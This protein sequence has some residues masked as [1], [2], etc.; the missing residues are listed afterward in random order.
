MSATKAYSALNARNELEQHV[1]EDLRKALA[2]RGATVTHYGTA[3]SHAPA[4]APCDISV[5]YGVGSTR[6]H[7]MVEVAQRPDASEFESIV[8]H[9]DAW[10]DARGSR[11]NLLYSGRS[12]SARM[13][14]LVRNENERRASLKR[15]GRIVFMKLDDLR[16]YLARWAALPAA[17]V[18]ATAI[19][20]VFK[21]T[22][23]FRD[24]SATAEVFRAALF[25][26]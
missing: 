14:R 3:A 26:T 2:P 22:D 8:S 9:L 25:P 15:A 13:A 5:E 10:V 24:D 11:V 19:D 20:P 7:L 23:A 1:T 16:A 4:S 6:R 17:E 18:P 21:R 12:T